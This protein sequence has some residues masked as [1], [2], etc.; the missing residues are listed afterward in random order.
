MYLNYV[1]IF[2][3]DIKNSVLKDN[4]NAMYLNRWYLAKGVSRGKLVAL[5]VY[6][7]KD[8]KSTT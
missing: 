1:S 7:R 5:N 6:V 4:K 3:R 2:K 8:L